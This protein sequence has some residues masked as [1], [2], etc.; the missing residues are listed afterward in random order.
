MPAAAPRRSSRISPRSVRPA[1]PGSGFAGGAADCAVLLAFAC[2]RARSR[3][4][5]RVFARSLDRARLR[6]FAR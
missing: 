1:R 4:L 2:V 6:A 5:A 3:A